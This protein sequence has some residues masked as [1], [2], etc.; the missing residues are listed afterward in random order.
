MQRLESP[1][2]NGVTDELRIV[3][4]DLATA[5]DLQAAESR[6][7]RKPWAWLGRRETRS[8]CLTRTGGRGL[9]EDPEGHGAAESSGARTA[10]VPCRVERLAASTMALG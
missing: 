2:V 5:A 1:R 10:G 9:A 6:R 8:T 3:A 7:W 4:R